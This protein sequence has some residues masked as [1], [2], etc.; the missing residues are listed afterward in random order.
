MTWMHSG[1]A[2]GLLG[3]ADLEITARRTGTAMRRA[4]RALA[5]AHGGRPR[6]RD[7]RPGMGQGDRVVNGAN[8]GRGAG[9]GSAEDSWPADLRDEE[10]QAETDSPD[11]TEQRDRGAAQAQQHA[12]LGQAETAQ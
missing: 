7:R 8:A 12:A 5:G 9:Q 2:L 6:G 10:D 4:A 11:K 1:A 3:V